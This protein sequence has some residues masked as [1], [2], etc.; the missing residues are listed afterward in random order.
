[1]KQQIF[2]KRKDLLKHYLEENVILME[3]TTKILVLGI[4]QLE[5]QLMLQFKGQPLIL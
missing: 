2:V 5:Q 1:M 4:L 3:L